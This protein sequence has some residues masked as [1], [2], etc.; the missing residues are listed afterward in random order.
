LCELEGENPGRGKTR[1]PMKGPIST[2]STLSVKL[3]KF[4]QSSRKKK[5]DT[6][7]TLA[8]RNSGGTK[9]SARRTRKKK[10]GGKFSSSGREG[11]TA[12]SMWQK[13]RTLLFFTKKEKGITVREKVLPYDGQE[14]EGRSRALSPWERVVKNC[15]KDSTKTLRCKKGGGSERKKKGAHFPG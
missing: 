2:I 5:E 12:C 15:L 8:A 7:C 11:R 14:K 6:P 13:R 9:S 10:R 3:R 1:S 4:F